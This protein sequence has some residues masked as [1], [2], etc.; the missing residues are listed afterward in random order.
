MVIKTDL[1]ISTNLYH[2]IIKNIKLTKENCQDAILFLKYELKKREEYYLSNNTYNL[3]I[4]MYFSILR[5][6][7]VICYTSKMKYEDELEFSYIDGLPSQ[8]TSYFDELI[9]IGNFYSNDYIEEFQEISYSYQDE[10]ILKILQ[11]SFESF[12]NKYKLDLLNFLDCDLSYYDHNFSSSQFSKYFSISFL[13]L[14]KNPFSLGS[15]TIINKLSKSKSFNEIINMLIKYNKKFEYFKLIFF[16]LL[17]VSIEERIELLKTIEY[18]NNLSKN[19]NYIYNI[20]SKNRF[21]YLISKVFVLDDHFKAFYTVLKKEEVVLNKNISIDKLFFTVFNKES[22]FY[23]EF[24]MYMTVE[25]LLNCFYNKSN[26]YLISTNN[27]QDINI[28]P[29]NFKLAINFINSD[30]NYNLKT[31]DLYSNFVKINNLNIIKNKIFIICITR[32][33]L[34]NN[35]EALFKV[36]NSSIQKFIK[37]FQ[38]ATGKNIEYNKLYLIE[39]NSNIIS[40]NNNFTSY[41]YNL[42]QE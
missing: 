12:K 30:H 22:G 10:A 25:T 38:K 36:F 15:L 17:D 5:K 4:S 16:D 42:K 7:L 8:N 28:L 33:K 26:N 14:I 2:N 32:N 13:L 1:D 11:K 41:L 34:K 39:S 29:N 40:N 31:V 37:N 27:I 6:K 21:S 23:R 9:F 3:V 24:E 35:K 18:K 19:I 20:I